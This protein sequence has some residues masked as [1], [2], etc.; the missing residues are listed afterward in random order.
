VIVRFELTRE[1]ASPPFRAT[2]GS[3]GW[4]IYA[5][6][7]VTIPSWTTRVIATGLAIELLPG[8]EAQV[9]PRSGLSSRGIYVAF[10]TVD[11]DYRGEIGVTMLNASDREYSV[12]CGARIAQIV[13]AP[14]P[15]IQFSPASSPLSLTA[16]GKG[17]FGSTGQ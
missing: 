17:G 12:A 7:D 10:G 2:E 11:S 5:A 16:R 13:V 6:E 3:S 8:Y 4:D 15:T 1:T 14:V 9:R